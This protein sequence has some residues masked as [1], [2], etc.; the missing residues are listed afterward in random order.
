MTRKPPAKGGSP[1]CYTW[2]IMVRPER[3]SVGWIDPEQV[4]GHFAHHIA[5]QVRDLEYFGAAGEIYEFTAS[6]PIVARNALV[7]R[8]LDDDN[9]EWLW[10]VDADMLFDKGHPMKLWET[11]N[12][13][14][15]RMVTGLA[16]IWHQ[17]KMPVPSLFYEDDEGGLRLQAR[18]VPDGPEEVA[19]CGLASALIHREVLE[20]LEPP[21][22]PDYRW[23]DFLPNEDIGVTGVEMTGIDVQ[24]FVR[25]RQLG[26]T[27]MVN[28]DAR[29]WH[30][31]TIGIGYDEW[32]R[33]W[34]I[35]DE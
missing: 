33:A 6:Q 22:H 31:E 26:Y 18:Y 23:F 13:Y 7:Q 16:M 8:F 21:R 25:A 11:A 28:P 10:M 4:S 27:L 2:K 12:E 17:Q 24:F 34:R 29:T 3:I 20:A 30:L 19:A 9:A 1:L 32:K 15:V 5:E 35:E 14:D